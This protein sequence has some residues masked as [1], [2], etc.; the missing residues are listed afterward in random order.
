MPTRHEVRQA[1]GTFA[2]FLKTRRIREMPQRVKASEATL[3]TLER[4]GGLAC[5]TDGGIERIDGEFV[6]PVFEQVNWNPIQVSG[7]QWHAIR[8]ALVLASKFL[9]DET[10]FIDYFV[11]L[12]HAKP[13]RA[14]E[15]GD[16]FYLDTLKIDPTMILQTSRILQNMAAITRFYTET[17]SSIVVPDH[18]HTAQFS[19]PTSSCNCHTKISIHLNRLSLSPF[20]TN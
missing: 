3:R 18:L 1:V 2:D 20:R 12:T 4:L 19:P 7:A 9:S 17:D 8:P 5:D 15:H 13:V 10:F 14:E 16:H 11:R 6:H